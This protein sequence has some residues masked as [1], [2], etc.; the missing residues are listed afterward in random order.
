L[1]TLCLIIHI[2][3]IL[4]TRLPYDG[5]PFFSCIMPIP[6]GCAMLSYKL[7]CQLFLQPQVVC[8]REHT[9]LMLRCFF[10]LR[11]YITHD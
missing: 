3:Y 6:P 8:H 1:N 11:V 2:L 5:L 9:L 7:D 4:G 10:Y